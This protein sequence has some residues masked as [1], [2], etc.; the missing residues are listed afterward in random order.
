MASAHA[1]RIGARCPSCSSADS[2]PVGTANA[3]V[4]ARCR[5]CGLLF[6]VCPPSEDE[7]ACIYSKS[8]LSFGLNDAAI[9][10]AVFRMKRRTFDARADLIE[11]FR[12]PGRVLDVGCASGAFLCSML[13][14]GWRAEGLEQS[15]QV[16]AHAARVSGVRVFAGTLE[17]FDA[18]PSTYDVVHMA[19]VIEH[20]RDPR[21]ALHRIRQ[22]IT[23]NGLLVLTTPDTASV[24]A[25]LLGRYW[26]NYKPEHLFYPDRRTIRML[27]ASEGFIVRHISR[28]T[29][30]LT[31]E[32]AC[33]YFDVYG[34]KMA[35]WLFARVTP[36]VP[37]AV[38][39]MPILVSAGD[40]LVM[41]EPI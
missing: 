26:P 11:Q 4:L 5:E 24:S 18:Q 27:L 8:Y 38:R 30:A 34:P 17:Q 31:M 9:A 16:A 3:V 35:A 13:A 12:R 40:M 21:G 2:T 22:L 28:A 33:D 23:P 29:K 20:L 6:A 32:F 15:A 37:L 39:R 19:D 14:R 10:D 1:A 36:H 25:R 41:A 7:L